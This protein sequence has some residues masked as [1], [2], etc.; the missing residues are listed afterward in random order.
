MRTSRGR[1]RRSQILKRKQTNNNAHIHTCVCT[2]ISVLVW[3]SKV[4]RDGNTFEIE[5]QDGMS[6]HESLFSKDE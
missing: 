6:K 4:C 1:S 3:Q 2:F 5:I